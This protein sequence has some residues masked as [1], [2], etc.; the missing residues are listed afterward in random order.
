MLKLTSS[1]LSAALVAGLISSCAS[2]N[3]SPPP[4]VV[5]APSP[6]P[7]APS[8][9]ATAPSAEPEA[10]PVV[11]Q[12]EAPAPTSAP[13]KV[14][15]AKPAASHDAKPTRTASAAPVFTGPNPCTH[16]VG[17]KGIIDQACGRGGIKEAKIVMKDMVKKAKKQGVK[18][19]CDTC[20]KDETDWSQFTPEAKDR[21]KEL[22]AI[23][24]K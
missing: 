19:D 22:L 20:H 14:P 23:Y 24:Q 17:G 7:E 21:F 3:S 12:A 6:A 11:A 15:A 1:L 10:P 9:E 4:A 13:T 16:A 8:A 18:F 5:A 2:S